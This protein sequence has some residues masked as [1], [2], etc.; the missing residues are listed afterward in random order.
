MVANNEWNWPQ[1]WL[2]KA[3]DL[4]LVTAPN[5]DTYSLD[6]SC[7]CDINGNFSSFSVKRAWEAI[8]P[9]G[10]EVWLYVHHLAEMESVPPCIHDIT[11]YLNPLANKRMAKSVIGRRLMAAT[12]YFV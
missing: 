2:L 8:R 9:C 5:L 6:V 3:P 11:M 7:W 1:S 4:G 12:S 10:I